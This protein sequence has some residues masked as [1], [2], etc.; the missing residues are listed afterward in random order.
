MSG[1][2]VARNGPGKGDS[3]HKMQEILGQV[4][5]FFLYLVSIGKQLRTGES[6]MSCAFYFSPLL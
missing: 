5:D 4:K 6:I 1:R 2:Q 3:N